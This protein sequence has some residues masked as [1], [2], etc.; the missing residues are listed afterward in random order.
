MDEY[1][2]L[3]KLSAVHYEPQDYMFCDGRTL[4]IKDYQAL[5]AVLGNNWE[6]LEEEFTLPNLS[7][8][9]GTRYIICVNGLYPPRH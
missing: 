6:N 7:S 1:L 8:P 5:A 3:I 4:K 9:E 2:G